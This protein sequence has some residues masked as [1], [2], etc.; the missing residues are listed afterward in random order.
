MKWTG[1][2]I[3]RMRNQLELSRLEFARFLSVDVRTVY[4][5]EA[6]NSQPKGSAETILSSLRAF[7]TSAGQGHALA[8]QE[9]GACAKIGGVGF[10]VLEW[11]KMRQERNC[12]RV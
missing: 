3:Q 7:N 4:R 11:L 9:L 8:L 5:W 2:Q 6:G 1:E 12:A 10:V